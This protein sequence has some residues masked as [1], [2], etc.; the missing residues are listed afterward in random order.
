MAISSAIVN[1]LV[2]LAFEGRFKLLDYQPL[3]GCAYYGM[4]TE[5][6]CR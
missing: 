3:L 2:L 1:E 4:K 5:N 6:T